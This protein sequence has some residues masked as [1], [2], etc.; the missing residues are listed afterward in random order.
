MRYTSHTTATETKRKHWMRDVWLLSATL[1]PN[2]GGC[3][4]LFPPSPRGDP[5]MSR[6]GDAV[7][8]NGHVSPSCGGG[9][10][11]RK[12]LNTHWNAQ[13]KVEPYVGGEEEE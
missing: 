10:N 4:I 12:L 2:T 3:I 9:D 6:S 7:A 5:E 8:L 13:A 1:E 11:A